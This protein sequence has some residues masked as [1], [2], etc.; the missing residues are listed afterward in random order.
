MGRPVLRVVVFPLDDALEVDGRGRAR[1]SRVLTGREAVLG[2]R[3]DLLRGH[4]SPEDAQATARVPVV[5]EG[6]LDVRRLGQAIR[7]CRAGAAV[8]ADDG[9]VRAHAEQPAGTSLMVR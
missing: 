5:H 9:D 2:R 4:T 3:E 1:Q 7:D 6:H 8:R